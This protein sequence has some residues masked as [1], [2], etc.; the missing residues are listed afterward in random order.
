MLKGLKEEYQ[1]L[2]ENLKNKKKTTLD[3][4]GFEE[5]ETF[6]QKMFKK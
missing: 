4:K 2:K 6:Y 1:S 5:A 3:I